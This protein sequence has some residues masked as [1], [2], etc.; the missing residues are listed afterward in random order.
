MNISNFI[1]NNNIDLFDDI[2]VVL[3]RSDETRL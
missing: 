3:L 2:L 1:T